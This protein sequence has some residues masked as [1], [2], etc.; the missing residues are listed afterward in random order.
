MEEI[1]ER[2]AMAGQELD[3]D[4]CV[5]MILRS[6]PSSFNTLTTALEARSDEELTLE[7]VKMKLVDEVAKSGTRGAGESVL[8]VDHQKRKKVLICYF[9]KKPGHKEKFCRA[10]N[11]ES[12]QLEA[13]PDLPQAKTAHEDAKENFSFLTLDQ[14]SGRDVWIIDSGATSHMCFN[15]DCFVSMDR[16]VKQDVYLADGK[17][18]ISEGVGSCKLIWESPEGKRNDVVL[19]DVMYVPKFETSI[20]SV[21]KLTACGA[22]VDF[23]ASGCRILKNNKVIGSAAMAGGLY[24]MRPVR[25]ALWRNGVSERKSRSARS[26]DPETHEWTISRHC[27]F[28]TH[29]EVRETEPSQGSIVLYPFS[30]VFPKECVADDVPVVLVP[31]DEHDGGEDPAGAVND[32]EENSDDPIEADSSDFEVE[33][34]GDGWNDTDDV[35]DALSPE[36]VEIRTAGRQEELQDGRSVCRTTQGVRRCRDLVDPIQEQWEPSTLADVMECS[37]REKWLRAFKEEI[38]FLHENSVRFETGAMLP[39]D[40]YFLE[41]S[42]YGLEQAGRVWNQQISVVLRNLEYQPSEA[43]PCLFVR[44]KADNRSFDGSQNGRF[45]LD[46][47][48]YIR[49]PKRQ[50]KEEESLPRKDDY[51]SLVSALLYVAVNIANSASTLGRKGSNLIE[52]GKTETERTLRYP[53]ATKELELG[54]PGR[55]SSGPSRIRGAF[56][57]L[58]E[59]AVADEA[60]VERGRRPELIGTAVEELACEGVKGV[61]EFQTNAA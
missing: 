3:E 17:K 6:L 4:L 26:I 40:V 20:I 43:D 16:S 12:S 7:L 41:K 31:D 15:P 14:K 36:D 10:K 48:A 52:T 32:G 24:Q 25:E 51:Q 21:K 1:F 47:N 33:V 53:N 5:A 54:G 30:E 37:D 35:D 56:G 50:Q 2:L 61:A 27:H 49:C 28:M 39:G 46:Q 59:V 58:P 8:K 57:G 18:T 11:G 34:S 44:K 42:C 45:W 23:D 38:Q 60:N 22:K 19:S 9:C 29:Q 55:R 13:E